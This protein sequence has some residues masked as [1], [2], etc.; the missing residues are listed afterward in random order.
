MCETVAARVVNIPT[1]SIQT[2]KERGIEI[3]T[4]TEI[5]REIGTGIGTETEKGIE[6]GS[7][8]ENEIVVETGTEKEIEVGKENG[9]EIGI[10]SEVM[11][12]IEGANILKKKDDGI[13]REAVVM[14]L[15]II[16]AGAGAEVV[17]GVG[18]EACRLGLHPIRVHKEESVTGKGIAVLLV[19]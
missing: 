14:V 15:G 8:I 7:T 19:T 4:M 12:M 17:A 16:E 1:E 3:G 18:V 5:V 10:E 6:N 13:M 11:I 9:S 2:E